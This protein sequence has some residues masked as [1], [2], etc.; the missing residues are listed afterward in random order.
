[1]VY[2]VLTA[3]HFNKFFQHVSIFILLISLLHYRST[4]NPLH[5]HTSQSF[6][7]IYETFWKNVAVYEKGTTNIVLNKLQTNEQKMQSFISVLQNSCCWQ[8]LFCSSISAPCCHYEE[9]SLLTSC[10]NFY[11]AETLC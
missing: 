3:L 7:N 4:P 11:I 2:L 8:P 6:I 9:T 1:M 5:P 10:T